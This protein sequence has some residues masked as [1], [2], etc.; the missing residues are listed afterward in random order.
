LPVLQAVEL[1]P[2]KRFGGGQNMKLSGRRYDDELGGSLLRSR[3][4]SDD[5][6]AEN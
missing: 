3:F 5:A 6:I 4:A 2:Q 1:Q